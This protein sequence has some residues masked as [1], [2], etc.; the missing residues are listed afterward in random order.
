MLAVGLQVWTGEVAGVGQL[1]LVSTKSWKDGKRIRLDQQ[2][3]RCI[4]SVAFLPDGK[5]V[6]VS[7]GSYS[8]D[9][10][11]MID[12]ATTKRDFSPGRKAPS[13]ARPVGATAY[14]PDGGLGA[15]GKP[16]TGEVNLWNVGRRDKLE[17]LTLP[18]HV[19]C[20]EFSPNGRLL[21]VGCKNGFVKLWE[22]TVQAGETQQ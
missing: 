4:D 1:T 14:S 6:V 12:I 2:Y 11:C 17:S 15:F 13:S 9:R 18:G 22:V 16:R 19:T 7:K 20:I 21:A 8:D 10:T 5:Q 3:D